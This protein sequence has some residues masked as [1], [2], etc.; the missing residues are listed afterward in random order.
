MIRGVI[1]D[2]GSTLMYFQDKWEEFDQ[3]ATESL[4]EFLN[5]HGIAV[6]QDFSAL[7]HEQRKIGWK[8]AE[9]TEIEH[10]VEQA[11]R[12]TLT[13][14]GSFSLDG[15]LPR[16]VE[17]YWARGEQQWRA[18]PDAIATLQA[19]RA[20][21]LRIGLI[22]NADDDGLVQRAVKRL[23]FAPYLSPVVSSAMEPYWRKPDARI[24]YRVSD[25][26]HLPPREIAM[27]GDAVR[28]DVVGAHRA[29]MRSILI[30]RG[31]NAP[32]QNIPDALVGDPTA[33]A[34]ATVRSLTEISAVVEKW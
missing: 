1:F 23:G 32:W 18:Y 2:L 17:V 5:E 15:L 19:L 22:S 12:N 8:L 11:L 31:D 16:A 33:Q 28:Y 30:D 29:G 20:R 7:F 4:A 34:D 6:G 27:V 21:G 10:T 14:M 13:Q 26:W 3:A 25:A 9:E 24:F